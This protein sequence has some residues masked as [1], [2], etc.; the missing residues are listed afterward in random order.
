MAR[1][2]EVLEALLANVELDYRGLLT[3]RTGQFIVRGNDILD[4]MEII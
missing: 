3:Q 1:I 4:P 2:N